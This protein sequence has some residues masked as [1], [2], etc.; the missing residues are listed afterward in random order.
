MRLGRGGGGFSA[1]DL[2]DFGLLVPGSG[3]RV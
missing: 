3:F 2:K 1:W